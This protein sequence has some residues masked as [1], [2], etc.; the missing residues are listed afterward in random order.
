MAPTPA[1]KILL[2]CAIDLFENG[3][4]RDSL[5]I[6]RQLAKDSE[7]YTREPKLPDTFEYLAETAAGSTR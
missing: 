7:R 6:L 3:A 2:K 4:R 1:R 5:P